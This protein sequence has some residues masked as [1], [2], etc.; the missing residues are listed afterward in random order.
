[1]TARYGHAIKG[2]AIKCKC[3]TWAKIHEL[4]IT[5]IGPRRAERTSAV[6]EPHTSPEGKSCTLNRIR[7]WPKAVQVFITHQLTGER[8]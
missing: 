7:P 2:P 6:V 1:M 5:Y 3:G 8:L 4:R